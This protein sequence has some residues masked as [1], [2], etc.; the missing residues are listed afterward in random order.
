V[1]KNPST[2]SA[3]RKRIIESICAIT[4][5]EDVDWVL[6]L[7]VTLETFD[8]STLRMAWL[9]FLGY[10]Q[11]EIAGLCNISQ[12]TVSLATKKIRKI[13]KKNR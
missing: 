9:S 4:V 2:R 5:G 8:D 12:N 6:D 13:C 11:K 7:R 1:E 10:K 3:E